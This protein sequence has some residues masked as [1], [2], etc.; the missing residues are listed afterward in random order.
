MKRVK[1]NG[2][3]S[4]AG[5][6]FFLYVSLLIDYIK[7]KHQ[8]PPLR[9]IT[10][11]QRKLRPETSEIIWSTITRKFTRWQDGQ[12]KLMLQSLLLVICARHRFRYSRQSHFLNI[13]FALWRLMIRYKII[14]HKCDT[15]WWNLLGHSD[16]GML[17]ISRPL[18]ASEGKFEW[19]T[20]STAPYASRGC[21]Q[22]I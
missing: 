7:V 4:C 9:S 22:T 11:T 3:A 10:P 13:S 21:P 18:Y 15:I 1:R 14:S 19:Q 16:G 2:S 5:E 12:S 8:V 6:F 17:R 20:N